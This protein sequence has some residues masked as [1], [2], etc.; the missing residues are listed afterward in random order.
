M[1]LAKNNT[2]EAVRKLIVE[3][4]NLLKERDITQKDIVRLKKAHSNTK[5][6]SRQF[7]HVVFYIR[8][9]Y[10]LR[11]REIAKKELIEMQKCSLNN[12]V[13][14]TS[15]IELIRIAAHYRRRNSMDILIDAILG[16]AKPYEHPNTTLFSPVWGSR[17]DVLNAVLAHT[18]NYGSAYKGA[19]RT[20]KE[21]MLKGANLYG[22]ILPQYAKL[23]M[24]FGTT[25]IDFAL[26]D[27]RTKTIMENIYFEI[28][29]EETP[30]RFETEFSSPYEFDLENKENLPDYSLLLPN[31]TGSQSFAELLTEESNIADLKKMTQQQTSHYSS[32]T[33]QATFTLEEGQRT[34]RKRKRDNHPAAHTEKGNPL[35][36]SK[37]RKLSE[38]HLSLAILPT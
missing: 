14:I 35:R 1:R 29:S 22:E 19:G 2:P 36:P 32:S 5:L 10:R 13:N 34:T 18:A 8:L 7:L 3:I 11:N 9:S 30:Q 23:L 33:S 28:K 38:K 4:N 15:I 12:E 26:N 27:G 24:N 17:T 31:P 21:L 37:G 25:P 6:D 16:T 20:F